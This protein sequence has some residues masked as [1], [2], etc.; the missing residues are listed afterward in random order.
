MLSPFLSAA[1]AAQAPTTLG[2]AIKVQLVFP[3][4]KKMAQIESADAKK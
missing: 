2:V 3:P 1:L 4:Q